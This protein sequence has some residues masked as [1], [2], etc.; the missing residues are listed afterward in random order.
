MALKLFEFRQSLECAVVV[1]AETEEQARNAIKMWEKAWIENGE[2]IGVGGEPELVDT[3]DP[4]SQDPDDLR[5]DAHEIV[6]AI[7]PN[8]AAFAVL[9]VS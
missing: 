9:L 4:R 7:E 1:A 8:P 2:F 3:R 5:D 6:K